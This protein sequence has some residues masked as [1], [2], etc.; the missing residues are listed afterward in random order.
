MRGIELFFNSTLFNLQSHLYVQD[1]EEI[2][3]VVEVLVML[4]TSGIVGAIWCFCLSHSSKTPYGTKERAHRAML[5]LI[6][7]SFLC[8]LIACAK[9]LGDEPSGLSDPGRYSL[10]KIL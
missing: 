9:L 5:A 8:I 7:V 10:L 4:A 6:L 1:Q 3:M 2:T